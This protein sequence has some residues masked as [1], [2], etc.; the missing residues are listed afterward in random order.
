M[1]G[2][3]VTLIA[4][5]VFRLD[6][7]LAITTGHLVRPSGSRQPI[8]ETGDEQ[9]VVAGLLIVGQNV[10]VDTRRPSQVSPLANLVIGLLRSRLLP[11]HV[12]LLNRDKRS[13][14]CIGGSGAGANNQAEGFGGG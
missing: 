8:N 13:N 4:I 12:P 10:N 9:L 2:T 7:Y 11:H 5:H 14:A 6:D 1:I 3:V